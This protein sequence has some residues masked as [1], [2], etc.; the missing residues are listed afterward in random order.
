MGHVVSTPELERI[1]RGHPEVH[2]GCVRVAELVADACQG[3]MLRD[4]YDTGALVSSVVVLKTRGAVKVRA[5]SPHAAPVEGGT[6]I[7]GPRRRKIYAK[8]GRPFV[9]TTRLPPPAD[10]L[11]QLLAGGLGGVARTLKLTSHRGMPG[12]HVM[13]RGAEQV[14]A[15]L[16]GATYR[17]KRVWTVE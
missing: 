1:L 15:V 5:K 8:P 17:R 11:G 12:R 14:A 9:F 10:S 13:Q 3:I 4:A 2:A 6:G 16:P 7:Y